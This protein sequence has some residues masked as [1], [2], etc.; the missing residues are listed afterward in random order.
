[1]I[2]RSTHD[3]QFAAASIIIGLALPSSLSAQGTAADYL[4]A[5][6][7]TR[8]FQNLVANVAEKPTW[9]DATRFWYRKSVVGGN[10]FVLVDTK[11]ST[12][13]P[14]FNHTSLAMGLNTVAN[15]HYNATTLP[16]TEFTY[17]GTTAIR[18]IAVGS[19]YSCTVAQYTCTRVG[20]APSATFGGA[21]RGSNPFFQ[22]EPESP[23][24]VPWVEDDGLEKEVFAQRARSGLAAMLQTRAPQSDTNTV[25]SPDGATEAYIYNYNIFVRPVT[26]VDDGGRGG[27]AGGGGRGAGGPPPV[28]ASLANGPV[29]TQ[30]SWDGSEGHPYVMGSAFN[31]SL[32][33][34]PDSKKIAAFRVTPGYQRFVRFIE[35]SPGDQLQPKYQ[36]QYYQKPGDEVTLREPALFDVATKAQLPIS[37]ALFPNAYALSG[38]E[39]WKD[40]RGFTFEYNQRGHQVY[41]IIEVNANT[42]DARAL[43]SDEPKTFFSYRPAADALGEPG[44]KWRRDLNDGAEIMWMSERD[45]WK[46]IYLYDGHIG[47]VKN[48]ITKGT[49]AVRNI[50]NVDSVKRQMFFSAGGK[51]AG[52]DPYFTKYYRINLDGTNLV[53]YTPEDGTHS[54]YFSPDS[55]FYVDSWTRV[56]LP[57]VTVLKRTADQKVVMPLDSGDASALMKAG[58]KMAEPFVAKG[59]DGTTDIWGVIFKPTN[60]DPKKKYP[61]IE[62]IYAGPQ[63]SFAPKTFA[64]NGA[65]RALAEVGF[66]VVQVDGMGTANRSKAFHDVAWKNIG[67]AG[68][69]DRILWHKAIAAKYPWYDATRVGVYGTSAG[70]QNAL[71]ALLFHGEFYKAAFAGAG[72]H[73][74]RM[75]KMWWNEQWMGWPI[76]PQYAASSNVDNAFK[77]KGDLLMVVGELDTNVDPS[78]TMQVV[79]QLIKHN[80]MFDLLVIPGAGHTN[81]GPYGVRKMTDFFVRSLMDGKP[82]HRNAE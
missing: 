47:K 81:G 7:L 3:R 34:S 32:R 25:R 24:E 38:I 43:V 28:A 48:Q 54:M 82:P 42:G 26:R 73:D 55:A 77:L 31:R 46:H 11:T 2:G 18:F 37:N 71:G 45:G 21:G 70:G 76:G 39:W 62:Q 56:D 78:S 4:R 74:N 44:S 36:E 41:R 22:P 33:W 80:K 20:S 79:N 65:T 5:D 68:F 59:R 67:D 1:M 61:V 12:K 72:C 35:S 8:H 53:S 75:D 40:S 57:P 10:A 6:S 60:F 69:P 16:F 14:A 23:T 9:L 63:G 64:V 30:L 17:D 13:T 51:D 49:F 66:I 50:Q 52:Q 29:G 58:F 27:R 15:Q 19:Q